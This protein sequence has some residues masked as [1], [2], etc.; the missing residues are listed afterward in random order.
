MKAQNVDFFNY[1]RVSI[2][3]VSEETWSIVLLFL[4]KPFCSSVTL[5]LSSTHLD[6]HSLITEQYIF[7]PMAP[8]QCLY[9]IVDLLDPWR[10][11]LDQG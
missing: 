3:F 9:M 4:Q 8:M 1:L 2:K 7:R 5:S 10:T 6:K 11:T